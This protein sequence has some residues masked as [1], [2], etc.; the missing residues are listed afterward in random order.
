MA[1][2][3]GCDCLED[4]QEQAHPE[5][6]H[7]AQMQVQLVAEMVRGTLIVRPYVLDEP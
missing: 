3:T 6:P 2:C 4:E 7:L 5:A 1:D